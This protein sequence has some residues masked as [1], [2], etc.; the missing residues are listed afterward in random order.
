MDQL[1][2]GVRMSLDILIGSSMTADSY[3]TDINEIIKN[4]MTACTSTLGKQAS[5]SSTA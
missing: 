3:H 4:D 2:S 5:P 1:E